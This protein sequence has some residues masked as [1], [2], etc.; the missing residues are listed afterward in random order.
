M[1]SDLIERAQLLHYVLYWLAWL[2]ER[3]CYFLYFP[4]VSVVHEQTNNLAF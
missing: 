4:G 3:V 2:V 1:L